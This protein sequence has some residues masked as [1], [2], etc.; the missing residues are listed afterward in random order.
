MAGDLGGA[1]GSF[2]TT[3]G[4]TVPVV[5]GLITSIV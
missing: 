3:D 1:N 2:T 4:K 5:G